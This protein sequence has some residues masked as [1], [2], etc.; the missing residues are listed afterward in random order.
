M[1]SKKPQ[2]KTIYYHPVPSSITDIQDLHIPIKV[3]KTYAGKSHLSECP[4]W[5]HQSSKIFTVYASS[6]LHL[7]I[8]E[9]NNRLY[10]NTLTQ[11]EF[12]ENILLS[13][14]WNNGKFALVEICN[15]YSNFYW[16]NDKDKNI[17]MSVLPHPLT[18]LNNNFYHCGGWFNLSNWN[19]QINIGAIVVD[20]NK[21]IIIKRGDPLYNIKFHT[22]NHNQNFNLIFTDIDRKKF[23]NMHKRLRFTRLK[24]HSSDFNYSDII[25]ESNEESKCPFRFFWKK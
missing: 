6:N 2:M 1:E 5:Q 9:N 7:Q 11:S 23:N 21:P 8:D 17:W 13:D 4:V 12:D 24:N 20:K 10:S 18:A 15:L 16:T 25:F 14:G 3:D 22:R 19:R